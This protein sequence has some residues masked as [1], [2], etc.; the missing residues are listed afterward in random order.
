MANVIC[1]LGMHRSGTSV[2]TRVLNLLG[3]DLG[4]ASQLMPP[5]KFNPRGFWEH[6]GIVRINDEI[7]ARLGGTWRD[8]P[9]FPDGWESSPAMQDLREE[10][11]ALVKRDF[12]NAL[13]W[14][15]K[16]PRTCITVPFWQNIIGAMRY[17]VCL[18]NPLEVV[19][20]L[21]HTMPFAHG[22]WLWLAYTRGVLNHTRGLPRML[23]F[24]EDFMA[25]VEREL[26]RLAA[27]LG[28][29]D[30][31]RQPEVRAAV[32]DFV[33]DGLHHQRSSPQNAAIDERLGDETRRLFTILRLRASLGQL[34]F[35]HG[36]LREAEA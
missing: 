21:E 9:Q 33:E 7:L 31:A 29:P 23:V 20:S 28:S 16:D 18:R 34:R 22:A 35:R 11:E 5:T 10:A 17:L 36:L 32:L 15:W 25:S 2:L 26:P 4:P 14:G 6:Q 8:V 1:V 12:G 13:T 30:S 24:Y 3:M 19:R 27:F